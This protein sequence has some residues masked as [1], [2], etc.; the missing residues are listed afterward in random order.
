[1]PEW[2]ELW[3]KTG[4]KGL[5]I[6]S[7]KRLAERLTGPRLLQRRQSV[8]PH[9]WCCQGPC[10]PS[11]CTACILKPHRGRAAPGKKRLASMHTGSLRSCPTLCELVDCGLARLLCRGPPGKNTG[12]FWPKLTTTPSRALYF[13]LS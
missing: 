4:Q 8:S 11:S 12:V 2:A 1:M 7:Y 6:A 13:L 9:S 3:I 5:L 10:K